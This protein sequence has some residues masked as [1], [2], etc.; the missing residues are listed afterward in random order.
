MDSVTQIVLGAAVGE[1]V[2]GKKAGNRAMLWGAVAG[3]IPDLDILANFVTDEMTALAFHRGLTHSLF[4]AVVAP[5]LYAYL[6]SPIYKKGWYQKKSYRK[7]GALWWGGVVLVF[8]GLFNFVPVMAKGSISYTM[9]GLTIL[10]MALL[11]WNLWKNYYQK[12]P[13]PVKAGYWDWVN[14]FFW[15]TITHPL[16]DAC[17]AFG[18]QLFQ[19]FSDYRVAFNTISV[20]DPLYTTPFLICLIWASRKTRN[21][22]TRRYIN[23]AGIIVSSAYLLFGLYHKLKVDRI[24]EAAMTKKEIPF[25]RFT[26]NPMILNNYLWNVVA[27]GDT[28]YYHTQFSI[29]DEPNTLGKFRVFPKN[30]HLV[31]KYDGDRSMEILK[32]FCNGYYTII[33]RP[34][35]KLQF[36]DMR[37]GTFGDV[38]GDD[39][40]H[41][42]FGFVLDEKNGV[43]D[44][45]Q[46]NEQMERDIGKAVQELW[47]G[48]KGR[49]VDQSPGFKEGPAALP[50]VNSIK[51]GI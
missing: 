8:M 9:L 13:E 35:G 46:A 22:P 32:W 50:Q 23:W 44:V 38:K 37:Y 31:K 25:N 17:T 29:N 20:A 34:D 4:F 10:I 11:S 12:E 27:E 43:L 49:E 39:P 28:A 51:P 45:H 1:V 26:T 36:N 6:V 48:I 14:L 30:H 40:G 42:I 7:V 41:Y 24:A 33:R 3:T 2:L 18:T 19:P 15:A 21:N 5:L 16:L 47:R